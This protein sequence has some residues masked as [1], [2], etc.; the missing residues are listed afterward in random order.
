MSEQ[1]Y[2]DIEFNLILETLIDSV[3]IIRENNKREIE[4]VEHDQLYF[5]EIIKKEA[6]FKRI[7]I[8]KE[9]IKSGKINYKRCFV[10]TANKKNDY[11]NRGSNGQFTKYLLEF[12]TF[13]QLSES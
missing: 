1:Y 4:L 10:K 5:E 2:N 11:S 6:R 12:M 9:R 7:K 8:V 13:E 3:E